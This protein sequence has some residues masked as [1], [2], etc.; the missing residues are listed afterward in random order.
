MSGSH[1]LGVRMSLLMQM[2]H[3]LKLQ[4]QKHPEQWMQSGCWAL[5]WRTAL[6]TARAWSRFQVRLC[7][8]NMNA[9]SRAVRRMYYGGAGSERGSCHHKLLGWYAANLLTILPMCWSQTEC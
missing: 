2:R 7:I 6:T 9:L 3:M 1:V 4:T 5:C 8:F